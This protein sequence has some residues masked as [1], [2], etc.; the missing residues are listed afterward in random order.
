MEKITEGDFEITDDSLVYTEVEEQS[1][2]PKDYLKEAN[3]NYL[4]YLIRKTLKTS[5]NLAGYPYAVMNI[6]KTT[7]KVMCTYKDVK[8][9]FDEDS[10]PVIGGYTGFE[11][12]DED[13]YGGYLSRYYY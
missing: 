8:T 13:V 11:D 7:H 3:E 6:V 1:S 10:I 5:P 12:D 4:K 2:P 9:V